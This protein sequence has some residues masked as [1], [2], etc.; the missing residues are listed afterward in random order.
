MT[1]QGTCCKVDQPLCLSRAER[2]FVWLLVKNFAACLLSLSVVFVFSAVRYP[3]RCR[4]G[5]VDRFSTRGR[6]GAGAGDHSG[7]KGLLLSKI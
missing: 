2:F 6:A 1:G 7:F 3:F 5:R 4:E